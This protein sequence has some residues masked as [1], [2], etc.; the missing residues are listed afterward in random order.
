MPLSQFD[1]YGVGVH[2][3]SLDEEFQRSVEHDFSYILRQTPHPS[4]KAAYTR[5]SP[6]C[7]GLPEMAA[8]PATPRN[9]CFVNGRR[10][11]V[12]YFGQALNSHDPENNS[13]RIIAEDP[14]LIRPD[15]YLVP[16]PLRTGVNPKN[17][18]ADIDADFTRLDKRIEFNSKINI[19]IRLFG[20]QLSRQK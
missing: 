18:P 1:F 11:Y 20:D 6:D 2:V 9:I 12:D 14:P 8:S 17:V 4:L 3:E 7:D 13:S 5:S 15:G 10:T 19:D 16:F